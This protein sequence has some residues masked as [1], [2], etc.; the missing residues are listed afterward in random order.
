MVSWLKKALPSSNGERARKEATCAWLAKS[1]P[2]LNELMTVTRF[3]GKARQTSTLSIFAE[4]AAFKARLCDRDSDNVLFMTADTFL[5][6][7]EALEAAL[8]SGTGDW[9]EDKWAKDRK[10]GK[11][12]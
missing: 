4:A 5:G 2:A 6:V 3:E 11:N 10:R 12:S 1:F 7:L 9:R 8:Q